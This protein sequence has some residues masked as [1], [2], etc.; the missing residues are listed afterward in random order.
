[1]ITKSLPFLG[2][3]SKQKHVYYKSVVKNVVKHSETIYNLKKD[4]YVEVHSLVLSFY[5]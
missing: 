1:M 3:K 2:L 5:F 4:F